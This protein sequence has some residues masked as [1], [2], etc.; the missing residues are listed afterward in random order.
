YPPSLHDALPI[1]F[2]KHNIR[3]DAALIL[4]KLVATMRDNPTLRIELPSHTDSRGTH[5]YNER[6]STRRAQ[7]AVNYIVSRGIARDRLVAKTYSE[8]RLSKHCSERGRFIQAHN[9]A[10]RHKEAIVLV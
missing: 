9:Q 8:T 4:D 1:Y 7:S 10:N 5:K 2:A 3:P 6:M